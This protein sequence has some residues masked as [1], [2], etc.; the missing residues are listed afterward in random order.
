MARPDVQHAQNCYS[1]G[2]EAE[3]AFARY[4]HFNGIEF[5][6]PGLY[7]PTVEK[8][9]PKGDVGDI[10]IDGRVVDVKHL[11]E[12][13]WTGE[14]DFPFSLVTAG[15]VHCWER[16]IRPAY[17]VFISGDLSHGY[18]INPNNMRGWS[19][20]MVYENLRKHEMPSYFAPKQ[21]A[22]FFTLGN[23]KYGQTQELRET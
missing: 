19:T 2:K 7:L 11:K 8:P 12:Y 20:K 3:F 4:L 6:M 13:T 5:T 14:D 17:M 23:T 21:W 9:E 10:I 1:A 22:N 16:M 15:F 18:R